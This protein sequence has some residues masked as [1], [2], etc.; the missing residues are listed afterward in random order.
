M[1]ERPSLEY[2]HAF[3]LCAMGVY[4]VAGRVA[5]L[6]SS[7]FCAAQMMERVGEADCHST[8]NDRA[9]IQAVTVPKTEPVGAHGRAPLHI[10][11]AEPQGVGDERVLAAIQQALLP[12]GRL[13]VIVSGWLARALPEWRAGDPPAARPGGIRRTVRLV[14]RHGFDVEAVYGFHGP[15]AIFWGVVSR[16]MGWI[17]RHDLADRCLFRMRANYVAVGKSATLAPVGVITARKE[18][19]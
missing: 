15:A 4:P 7:D 12:E 11:W 16:P 14:R 17:G 6:T 2:Q 19:R 5:I 9:E 18:K 8:K 3:D 1:V 10:V 13:W